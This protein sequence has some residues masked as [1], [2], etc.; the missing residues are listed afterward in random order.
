MFVQGNAGPPG[1][2]GPEGPPGPPGV[3]GFPKGPKVKIMHESR[4]TRIVC[5]HI[6]HSN[7]LRQF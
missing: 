4:T 3:I 1:G 5:R 7:H 6:N 2:V